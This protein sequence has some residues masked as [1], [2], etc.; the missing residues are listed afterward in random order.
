MNESEL[1]E[2][3]STKNLVSVPCNGCGAQ[4]KYNAGIGMMLC[5]HCGNKQE[6]P[7]ARD[8][9]IENSFSD[10]LRMEG[11][12][13][14]LDVETRSFDCQN[15][16]AVTMVNNNEPVVLCDFCGSKNINEAAFDTNIIKPAGLLPFSLDEKKAK[17]TFQEWLGKGWFHP[18][19][20]SDVAK[21]SKLA[22]MYVPFWTYDAHTDSHWNAD[23]GYYYYVTE[24]YTDANGERQSRQVR[25][26]R[27]VPANGFYQHWFDD[28]LVIGS[29]GVSQSRIQ[30]I[31]PF[32]LEN[33]VNY[34]SRYILGWKAEVYGV[35]LEQGYQT[36]D[37][38][39]DQHIRSACA[40]MV[41]GDTYR[42]LRV[43]THKYDITFKHILLPVWIAAYI[44]NDKSFQVVVNGVTG[45]ISGEKPLSVWKIALAILVFALLVAG[46]Y[47]LT[48][49]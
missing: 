18:S 21:L 17:E 33:V 35:D 27:W 30:N 42:N 24:Y 47:L 39:M 28:V 49:K 22:G 2:P 23:A 46:V 8:Q 13:R 4:M 16:G 9:I 19:K 5:D 1:P 32:P 6:L 14:G 44:Y 40:R 29:K 37:D 48:R 45:K 12:A 20:L 25:K 36:A 43:N 7:A 3:E 26:V 41:P 10:A 15:C 11:T 31:Y 34:D 38:I